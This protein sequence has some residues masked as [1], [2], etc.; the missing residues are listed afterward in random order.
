M[1]RLV[2]LVC[3]LACLIAIGR[4]VTVISPKAN[5]PAEATARTPVPT[6]VSV[7]VSEPD[8]PG[9]LPEVPQGSGYVLGA[10]SPA[11]GSNARFFGIAIDEP[12]TETDGDA[13]PAQVAV[14]HREPQ[15]AIADVEVAPP[16]VLVV[17]VVDGDTIEVEGGERVRY[18]GID[19]PESTVEHECYGEEAKSRNR[20]LVEGKHVRLLAD[21]EDR[22]K[23]G[24]LLRYVYVGDEFINLALANEGFATQLTIPP[25]VAH[26][27]T[28]REAVA[29]AEE[30]GRGLW[31]GCPAGERNDSTR[32]NQRNYDEA[33]PQATT[34]ECPPDKT[35]KGNAQS[36]IYHLPGGEFYAKTK[37]EAC[38]ATTAEAE[39]AG[40][41]Q[42]K[43]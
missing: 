25:N 10:Q 34:S 36:M 16:T 27:D 13:Q 8:E 42:S 18:I 28:F 21:A 33:I 37:P 38:F 31:G 35:I 17:A 3:I 24:R 39:S 26:A 7:A 4:S 40:Y 1:Q 2:S 11:P 14:E 9:Q 6:A 32:S 43:R 41:R 23:Y 20:E 5:N 29:A 12:T 19:T 15:E 30:A 22:D